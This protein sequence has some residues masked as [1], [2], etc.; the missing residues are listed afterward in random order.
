M[1]TRARAHSLRSKYSARSVFYS[2]E[3]VYFFTF[4]INPILNGHARDFRCKQNYQFELI[5]QTSHGRDIWK[6]Q[7]DINT[8]LFI[9]CAIFE[10]RRRNFAN[11]LSFSAKIDFPHAINWVQIGLIAFTTNDESIRINIFEYYWD[12]FAWVFQCDE[13]S[14]IS[15]VQKQKFIEY[16]IIGHTPSTY[17][18]LY[19]VC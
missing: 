14:S 13:R 19:I 3:F 8:Q 7:T 17:T 6:T 10:E 9:I 18:L 5:G 11:R 1:C 16:R 4:L 2:S 15:G 12:S